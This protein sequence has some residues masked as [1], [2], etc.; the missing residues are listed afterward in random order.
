MI[1]Y[2]TF[3]KIIER[4]FPKI[5]NSVKSTNILEDRLIS[6]THF[7]HLGQII[8]NPTQ[9]ALLSGNEAELPWDKA[10]FQL[11]QNVYETLSKKRYTP[12]ISVDT[13]QRT[14]YLRLMYDMPVGKS[15]VI[16]KPTEGKKEKRH[17]DCVDRIFIGFEP[18][19][20]P[21]G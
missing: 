4:K 5:I 10:N 8:L 20:H 15:E 18:D 19:K 21:F 16:T 9:P 12:I 13:F 6:G 17:F 7:R 1:P 3:V 14:Q 11:L 2:E